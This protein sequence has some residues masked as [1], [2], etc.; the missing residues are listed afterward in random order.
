MA[1]LFTFHKLLT[2]TSLRNGSM[3]MTGENEFQANAFNPYIH[4]SLFH[5]S[6][7]CVL[8]KCEI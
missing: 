7:L 1:I 6:E 2:S 5:I 8:L 3:L 4:K